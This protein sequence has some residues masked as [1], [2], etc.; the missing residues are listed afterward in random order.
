MFNQ[1]AHDR[2]PD[3][4]VGVYYDV[5]AHTTGSIPSLGAR[6]KR[7]KP[8]WGT[9][10]PQ[11]V[12][13]SILAKRIDTQAISAFDEKLMMAEKEK[14][15]TTRR[16]GGR[17]QVSH[18]TSLLPPPIDAD[19]ARQSRKRIEGQI[20]ASKRAQHKEQER[21]L[22]EKKHRQTKRQEQRTGGLT[23]GLMLEYRQEETPADK[24]PTH[25]KIEGEHFEDGGKRSGVGGAGGAGAKKGKRVGEG[26]KEKKETQDYWDHEAERKENKRNNRVDKMK[27]LHA[28]REKEKILQEREHFTADRLARIGRN[29]NAMVQVRLK[30]EIL[31]GTKEEVLFNKLQDAAEKYH[32][33]NKRIGK[34]HDTRLQA[35][36]VSK[37]EEKQHRLQE[38]EHNYRKLAGVMSEKSRFQE[39]LFRAKFVEH[40]DEFDHGKAIVELVT[41][42]SVSEPAPEALLPP[43]FLHKFKR[44]DS[45]QYFLPPVKEFEERTASGLLAAISVNTIHNIFEN[46]SRSLDR[47]TVYPT[48]LYRLCKEIAIAVFEKHSER[49]LARINKECTLHSEV[50]KKR[51]FNLALKE[52]DTV[53][54]RREF[55]LALE[56]EVMNVLDINPSSDFQPIS[57][58]DFL[59]GWGKVVR[60]ANLQVAAPALDSHCRLMMNS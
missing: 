12:Y 25:Q 32:K 33:F 1:A 39:P 59:G 23:R 35:V 54:A 46:F 47:T 16:M 37:A 44:G 53:E 49:E 8:D 11:T 26:I 50:Q 40:N 45:V 43:T 4:T 41:R 9:R 56:R 2:V 28:Q 10:N 55:C 29:R 14:E 7:T 36:T 31:K 18:S 21:R 20:Q 17:L 6:R 57:R 27:A 22:L 48:E 15:E 19:S 24:Y 52:I 13:S 42:P 38:F 60:G 51:L 3:K 5:F 34:K 58:S 30:H